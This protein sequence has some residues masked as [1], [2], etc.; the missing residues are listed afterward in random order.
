MGMRPENY[1]IYT[2]HNIGSMLKKPIN[3]NQLVYC[4]R[5]GFNTDIYYVS[6]RCIYAC[7]CLCT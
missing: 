4:I 6:C 7:V 5:I 2:V 3:L 1:Y